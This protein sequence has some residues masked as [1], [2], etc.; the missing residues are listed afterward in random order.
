MA[1]LSRLTFLAAL[2][3]FCIVDG[4]EPTGTTVADSN[5]KWYG[6]SIYFIVTDRFAKSDESADSSAQCGGTDWC[7]GTLKGVTRRLDYIQNMG[8][9]AIWITPVVKQVDW[10]DYWNGTGFHGYWAQ[11]FFKID[12]HFGTEDDLLELKRECKKRDILLMLD[13][14]ANHV[15]PIH[16]MDHIRALGEGLNSIYGQQFHQ[17]GR[18]PFQTLTDYMH[19]PATW[20]SISKSCWPMY[21]WDEGCNY[22]LIEKGWYG[23]LADLNQDDP[24]TREYLLK[25]IRFMAKKYSIDGFRLDTALYLPKWFLREFQEASGTFMIGEVITHNFTVHRSFTPALTGILNFPVTEHLSSVFGKNGSMVDLQRL[26]QKQHSMD[27]PFE[28]LLGN[29]VDNHDRERFLFKQGGDLSKL[30]NGLTWTMLYHGLPII[31]YGTEQEYVSNRV[32]ERASMWPHYGITDIYK[33]LAELNALR[34]KFGIAAG[35][36]DRTLRA[37][38]LSA[39]TKSLAFVRGRLLVLLTNSGLGSQTKMCIKLDGL[40]VTWMDACRKYNVETVLGNASVPQCVEGQL[41]MQTENGYPSVFA[42]TNGP[43]SVFTM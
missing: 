5:E 35:G 37:I 20:L 2:R 23:D 26:L 43:T 8:F 34:K 25:W 9:D 4:L 16:S 22:T 14:V 41:C 3:F 33:F 15:G 42:V 7:G 30:K 19:N 11:D 21:N 1:G 29:F 27:Y 40:P 13:V 28:G 12:P 32:E 31:Y 6:R 38:P 17:L 39:T 24:E 36:K 18:L 10:K